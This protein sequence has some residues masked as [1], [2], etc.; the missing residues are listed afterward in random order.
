MRVDG[1][2]RFDGQSSLIV[3]RATLFALLIF[4]LLIAGCAATSN[5][6][7]DEEIVTN[8]KPMATYT[9]L[10]VR[11]FELKREL[12][13]DGDERIGER[14]QRYERIPVQLTEQIQRYVKARRV[15]ETVSRST[16]PTAT[17]LILQ[18]KFTR[19][20]R[21]RITI[22]A[23]LLDGASGQE[24]AYFQQTLWDVLDTGEAVGRL[25]RE[26]ADFLDRIQ[27]K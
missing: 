21:F 24:V 9:S 2:G 10:L 13:D 27:Y 20:G 23:V 17:T 14:E 4:L 6:V 3:S 19:M 1:A 11:D 16:K 26:V 15:F 18:G 12:Y 25:G 7:I 22:E 8:Q 5:V